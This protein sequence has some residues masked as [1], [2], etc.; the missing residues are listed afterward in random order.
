MINNKFS[1]PLVSIIITCY[2]QANFIK[3]AIESAVNQSY[4][5]IEI[6]VVNDGST[7]NSLDI[8]QA[9]SSREK[10][11]IATTTNGGPAFA[12]NAG[13]KYANGEY[14]SFLDGDDLYLPNRLKVHIDFLMSNYNVDISY[15]ETQYF[16]NQQKNSFNIK[17]RPQ[18]NGD[19]FRK[20]IRGNFIP[21]NAFVIKSSMLRKIGG[22][23]ESLRTHEDWDMLLRLSLAGARFGH[24]DQITQLVRIHKENITKNRRLMVESEI[25]VMRKIWKINLS[26]EQENYLNKALFPI[27]L[28]VISELLFLND[29][30]SIILWISSILENQ[31]SFLNRLIFNLIKASL[32]ILGSPIILPILKLFKNKAYRA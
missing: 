11:F 13:L 15:S 17:K 16:Y 12:R 31:P 25:A 3:S 6:I 21:T 20:L 4:G 22:Y 1:Y 8:I 19:I 30:R 24:I 7:D 29:R 23:D 18:I 14:I 2:N 32:P 10:I 5:P 9:I 26:S 28:D 27:G